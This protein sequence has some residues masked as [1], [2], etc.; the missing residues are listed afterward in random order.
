MIRVC[1]CLFKNNI[2]PTADKIVFET[3]RT[4]G[5]YY[6]IDYEIYFI[7]SAITVYAPE[8]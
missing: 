2:Q 7:I 4:T 8:H 1:V 6:H 3:C 5:T